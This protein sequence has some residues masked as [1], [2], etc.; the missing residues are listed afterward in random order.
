MPVVPTTALGYPTIE[1]VMNLIRTLVNDTFAGATGTPGEGR[2]FTDSAPF[3]I[4]ILN[5][6]VS[7]LSR[8]LENNGVTTFTVDNFII[9]IPAAGTVDP[10]IQVSLLYTGYFNG[11]TNASSPILPADL[12]MP[13]ELWER[14][15]GTTINFK[16]MTF[17]DALPS[18]AQADYL[19]FW[20]W[21][22]DQLNLI[23]SVQ[24]ID[25]RMRYKS[26]ILP[27]IT[28]STNFSQ[29]VIACA[30]C[31]DALAYQAAKIYAGSR[32]GVGLPATFEEDRKEA[33]DQMILRYVRAQQSQSHQ[34]APYGDEGSG[35]PGGNAESW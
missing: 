25:V 32:N 31:A 13:L 12:L 7:W 18:M 5:S 20:T 14:P 4:P 1:D 29:T 24:S 9:T 21:N 10:G 19:R 35:L 17:M 30:D 34:R 23:G 2:T 6:A 11:V 27:K 28:S 26:K 22:Q 33:I 8:K 15:T 3:T 16:S